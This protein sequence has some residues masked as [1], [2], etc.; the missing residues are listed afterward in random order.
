LRIKID[1][2]AKEEMGKSA[3]EPLFES[4]KEDMKRILDDL[5]DVRD[6]AGEALRMAAGAADMSQVAALGAKIEELKSLLNKKGKLTGI[7][8][9][10][11]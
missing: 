5:G 2:I 11:M 7:A 9:H 4:V 3:L 1:S 8:C 6:K 10:E